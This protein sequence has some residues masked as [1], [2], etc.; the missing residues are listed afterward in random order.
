[1]TKERKTEDYVYAQASIQRLYKTCIDDGLNP[2]IFME[3]CLFIA[4]QYQAEFTDKATLKSL[5]DS[6]LKAVAGES[7]SQLEAR[8]NEAMEKKIKTIV[9]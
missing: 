3:S 6:V 7:N 4:L 1:M 8:N 5:I 2:D 9:H